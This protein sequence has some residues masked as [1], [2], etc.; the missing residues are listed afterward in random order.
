M[1]VTRPTLIF[2][3]AGRAR[4]ATRRRL[5]WC[6]VVVA[7]AGGYGRA[8]MARMRAIRI[9]DM[10]CGARS[11]CNSSCSRGPQAPANWAHSDAGAEYNLVA[12]WSRIAGSAKL[13]SMAVR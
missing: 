5:S 3:A 7:A 1:S 4:P 12:R 10:D 13:A 2:L 6:A 11:P 8:P 9:A